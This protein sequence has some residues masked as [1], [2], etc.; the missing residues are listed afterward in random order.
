MDVFVLPWQI[1]KDYDGTAEEE[2]RRIVNSGKSCHIDGRAGTGKSYLVNRIMDELRTQNKK[3]M[4][5]SPTNKGA[6]IIGGH[7]IHSIYFKY[8]ANKSKLFSMMEPLEYIFID[9]VSMMTEEFY[10][11][12][13]L[14][15]RTFSH[16]KFIIAGDFGQLPPVQDDWI[17]D[18]ENSPALNLLCDGTRVQLGKCRRSDD[19]LY[20]LCLH[21]SKVDK[22]EFRVSEKTYLNLAYTHVTRKRVNKE[23]MERFLHGKS[24]SVH[25]L[26]DL[27]NS[28][29]QEVR[30]VP[31]MPVLAHTTNK[32]LRFMNSQLFTIQSVNPEVLVMT[33]ESDTIQIPT[34]DFHQYFYL[35]FCLT[36]H[37]SQGE[38]FTKKYTIHDWYMLSDKAKYVALS[39]G[40]SIHNI[41]IA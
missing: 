14:I 35:G 18:Y 2:A 12:F 11:L 33:S 19:A 26:P 4:G 22:H 15:K 5:F 3:F 41:Q 24:G 40:S 23:C 7:T 28:K 34:K 36:I 32:K 29:T 8:Q 38:T 20:Q 16:I 30:L 39:R 6:R 21:T 25:I 31:G 27:L 17:G 10:Q 13:I 9:E 1:Q 37:A